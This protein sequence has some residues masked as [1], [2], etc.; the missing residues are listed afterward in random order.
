MDPEPLA[1]EIKILQHIILQHKILQH[2]NPVKK[3][4][5]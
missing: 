3:I 2:K 1:C 5:L 4:R